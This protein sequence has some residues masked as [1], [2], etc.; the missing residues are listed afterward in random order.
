MALIEF[1]D[2]P[3]TTTPLTASNLNNNFEECNNIIESGSNTNGSYIKFS[4]GTLIQRTQANIGQCTFSIY[5]S[6]Y[7]GLYTDHT[8]G[9]GYVWTF[10]VEFIDTDIEISSIVHSSAYMCSSASIPT[11]TSVNVNYH[12][13]YAFTGN[14][15][16]SIIAIGRW[17]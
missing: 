2:L 13:N 1:Q 10:P 12:T 3:N 6:S 17:K 16:L 5:S 7:P 4:D 9:G 15:T 8:H 14:I 11:T